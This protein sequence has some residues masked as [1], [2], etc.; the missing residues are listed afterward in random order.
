M[1]N[2]VHKTVQPVFTLTSEIYNKYSSSSQTYYYLLP[3]THD[4]ELYVVYWVRSTRP[5][6]DLTNS[7]SERIEYD[8]I[9]FSDIIVM[10]YV[11]IKDIHVRSRYVHVKNLKHLLTDATLSGRPLLR[12]KGALHDT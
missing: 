4:E 1:I 6:S 2:L 3:S 10:T 9:P 11:E 8:D 7:S 5:N 12:I